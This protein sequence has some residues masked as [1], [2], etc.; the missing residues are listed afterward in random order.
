MLSFDMS[1][2][3]PASRTA[4][5]KEA[6][7]PGGREAKDFAIYIKLTFYGSAEKEM[8]SMD[9]CKSVSCERHAF[10]KIG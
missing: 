10:D 8:A 9:I 7:K 2:A 6:S 3:A 4:P 1:F 5:L